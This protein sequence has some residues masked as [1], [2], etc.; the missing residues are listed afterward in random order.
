MDSD[1]VYALLASTVNPHQWEPVSGDG[2]VATVDI[3]PLDGTSSTK[4]YTTPVSTE[5]TGQASG[6]IVPAVA[7]LVKLQT[8]LRGPANRGR[9]FLPWL[10][11]GAIDSGLVSSGILSTW[12][13]H[14]ADFGT[15]MAAGGAA[16]GVASYKHGTWHQA[17]T[18]AVEHVCATQK[19]RQ[20]QLR[21]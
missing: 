17:T 15:A 10:G 8:G 6:A 11:E 19:R 21:H 14:W 16:L 3:L 1:D 20:E 9:L 2:R 18:I 5:W 13:S 12:S 4:T 7:G